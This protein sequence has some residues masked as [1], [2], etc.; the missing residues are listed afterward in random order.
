[1]K[2]REEYVSKMKGELDRLNAQ[3]DKWQ[4]QAD[5]AGA[6]MKKR[7]E[8]QLA[9]VAARREDARYQL[10]LVEAASGEAWSELAAGADQAWAH[11]RD[12]VAAARAHF[13]K[14]AARK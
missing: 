8:K 5:A 12:A 3:A 9:V 4:A 14:E 11:M 1:M 6:E 7:Y 13:E 10:K 2:K